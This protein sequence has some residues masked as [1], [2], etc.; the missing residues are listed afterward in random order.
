ML[1]EGMARVRQIRRRHP[2]R[3]PLSYCPLAHRHGSCTGIDRP[4]TPLTFATGL[5]ARGK[6]PATSGGIAWT[7]LLLGR[8]CPIWSVA[9]RRGV[10]P[11]TASH[12]GIIR[13]FSPPGR[14][15]RREAS[16]YAARLLH[17][18]GRALSCVLCVAGPHGTRRSTMPVGCCHARRALPFRRALP[19]CTVACIRTH[20]D[21]R[22]SGS[23]AWSAIRYGNPSSR[24]RIPT[25][26]PP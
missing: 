11:R 12:C 15:H 13:R 7:A 4:R 26:M 1:E 10:S 25:S 23:S 24:L 8:I 9:M 19:Y 3:R 16:C 6:N 14:R 17:W 22:S 18:D 2:E 20:S 5:A 21:R